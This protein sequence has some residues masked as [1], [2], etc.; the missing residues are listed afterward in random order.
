MTTLPRA[1]KGTAPTLP[2]ARFHSAATFAG[3]LVASY[4]GSVMLWVAVPALVF[5]WQPLVVVSGSMAPLFRPGDLVLV[6]DQRSKIGPGTIIAFHSSPGE[7]VLHR[8]IGNGP[9]GSYRTRGDANQSP[10]SGLVQPSDVIGSGR[11]LV[12]LGGLPRVWGL[13][14]VF[15]ITGLLVGA[16]LAWRRRPSWAIAL[17]AAVVSMAGVVVASASFAD[18]TSAGGSSLSVVMVA[19]PSGLTATCGAIGTSSVEVDLAWTASAT[20]G[21]TSY[22]ILHDA[23]G[24]GTNFSTIGSVD[25]STTAFTHSVPVA[26]FGT[27]THTYVARAMV[28]PWPSVNSNT[29]AVNIT[30]VLLVYTCSAL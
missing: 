19:P 14:W 29:D 15:A 5:G 8:V 18:A 16:A 7:V 26:L 30:Q 28:E 1:L 23:P 11:V 22:Q 21:I 25:G 27:G 13:G 2:W 20:M 4:V 24:G 10:D 12:P 9:D 6:D 3:W 17:L